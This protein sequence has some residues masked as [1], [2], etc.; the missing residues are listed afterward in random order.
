VPVRATYLMPL[1]FQRLSPRR[2]TPRPQ[3]HNTAKG[4]AAASQSFS[5]NA[6]YF[7]LQNSI[8]KGY[9]LQ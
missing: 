7:H 9:M 8:F 4:T 5:K 2:T 6:H 1:R 3:P